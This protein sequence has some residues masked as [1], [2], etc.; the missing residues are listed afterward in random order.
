MDGFDERTQFMITFFQLILVVAF[1][2]DATARLEPQ[3]PVACYEGT[4]DDGLTERA[5]EA[6]GAYT[7]PIRSSVV[8]F[9]FR[10]DLHGPHLGSSAERTCGEGVDEG[11]NGIGLGLECATDPTDKM[12]DMR[13]ELHI[14]VEVD[15]HPIAVSG[16]VIACEV[17][18]HDMFGVFLGVVAQ[19]FRIFTVLLLVARPWCRTRYGVDERLA[20]F[21][22]AM[23][24]RRGPE[25]TESAEIEIEEIRR[26]IN[27]SQRAVE[28]EVIALVSLHESP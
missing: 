8:G 16:E 19:I 13:I 9:E 12:N 24:L 22:G 20:L 28:F 7:P 6:N 11:G 2:H 3:F 15:P 4:Y 27:A 21:D 5:V 25:D 18:E 17:N 23:R 26:G 14:L 1:S 10:D